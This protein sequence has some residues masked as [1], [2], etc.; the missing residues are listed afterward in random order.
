MAS[1]TRLV[2]VPSDELAQ[3]QFQVSSGLTAAPFPVEQQ[4]RDAFDTRYTDLLA[5]SLKALS[6]RAMVAFAS[7]FTLMLAASA[8]WLWL[9]ILPQPSPSQLIGVG[10]YAV[11][12]LILEFVRRR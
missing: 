1:P 6:Q 3:Q 2:E 12:C 11:F 9:S 8:F 10:M 5:L 4:K 7:L